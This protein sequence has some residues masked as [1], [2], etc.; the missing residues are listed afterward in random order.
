MPIWYKMVSPSVN[1]VKGVVWANMH[2]PCALAA[3]MNRPQPSEEC[4]GEASYRE[5]AVGERP[6]LEEGS[7]PKKQTAGKRNVQAV[8]VLRNEKESAASSCAPSTREQ[9]IFGFTNKPSV[10]STLAFLGVVR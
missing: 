9:D 4:G 5:F 6:D 7:I 8:S 1:T 10:A 3:V 2:R